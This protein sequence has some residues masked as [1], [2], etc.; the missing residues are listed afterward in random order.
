MLLDPDDLTGRASIIGVERKMAINL[1]NPARCFCYSKRCALGITIALSG[2]PLFFAQAPRGN[3]ISRSSISVYSLKDKSVKVIYSADTLIEAPNW[4][5]DG[6]YLLI[7]TGGNL[8][9]LPVTSSASAQPAKIDL[10][11]INRCNNDKE[12]SPDGSLIAFSSSA[13]AKGSQVYTVSSM[14]GEPKLIVP[15]TPSYFHAFSPD[16]KYMSFV[17]Q[18]EGNFDLFRVRTG[19][20]PQ[21]RLTVNKG[22]DD[23]PDYSPDG[24]W[25]YFNSDRSGS[26]DIWRIPVSGGGPDDRE[27]QQVTKDDQEDWFPHCSPN[28]KWLVFLTFPKGT[29]GHNDR[30]DGVELRMMPLPGAHIHA[31]QP[32]VLSKFFGGQGTI[33]V[34]SWSPDSSA[35]AYVTYQP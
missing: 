24:K 3:H 34:N 32:V 4:S 5:P 26:W 28:G 31:A 18:R 19:G 2:A 22:Y 35:F 11:D 20:G 25:I 14:G 9:K 33:N 17:A 23:G 12:V 1:R 27:A 13:K 30:I 16:G 15:E 8:Y 21:E 7:N 29:S 6:K 10:A